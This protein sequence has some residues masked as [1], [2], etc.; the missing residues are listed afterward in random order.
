MKQRNTSTRVNDT[1]PGA[2][3]P[4]AGGTL[5]TAGDT[6]AEN[7]PSEPAGGWPRDR[8]TGMPGCYTRDPRTGVRTPADDTARA[9]QAEQDAAETA[10]AAS[11]PQ[12]PAEGQ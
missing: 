11:Q 4:A 6:S 10:A 12:P 1:A 7:A 2:G 8:Y 3:A 5:D 9:V